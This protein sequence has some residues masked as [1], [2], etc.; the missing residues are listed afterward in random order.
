MT[1]IPTSFPFSRAHNSEDT[2]INGPSTAEWVWGTIEWNPTPNRLWYFVSHDNNHYLY[3]SVLDG[4]GLFHHSQGIKC[5]LSRGV[6]PFIQGGRISTLASPG[7]KAQDLAAY[8][9]W[10]PWKGLQIA[11]FWPGYWWVTHQN[12]QSLRGVKGE[13]RHLAPAP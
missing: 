7:H 3:R 11:S 4:A 12:A 5:C 9:G 6:S 10:I 8:P 2:Y 1:G 13:C